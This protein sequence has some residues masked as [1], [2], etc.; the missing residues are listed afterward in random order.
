M[1]VGVLLLTPD[2]Q[3]RRA[4]AFQ[5]IPPS[6]AATAMTGRLLRYR[7]HGCP[8]FKSNLEDVVVRTSAKPA[9]C[10]RCTAERGGRQSARNG[11]VWRIGCHGYA[12]IYAR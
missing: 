2:A 11:A 10:E 8:I 12:P 3:E 7:R 4:Q 5:P 6:C 1:G 9:H